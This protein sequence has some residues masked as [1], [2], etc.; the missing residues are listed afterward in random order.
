MF[1]GLVLGSA[2]SS[3]VVSAFEKRDSFREHHPENDRV[4]MQPIVV[5]RR[6]VKGYPLSKALRWMSF[7]SDELG[8]SPELG[9][10]CFRG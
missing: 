6:R 10:K 9:F 1:L 4:S 7:E 5:V 8:D 2:P 3:V